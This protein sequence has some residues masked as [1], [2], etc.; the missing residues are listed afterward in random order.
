MENDLYIKRKIEKKVNK[1]EEPRA[2]FRSRNLGTDPRRGQ[3]PN[4]EGLFMEKAKSNFQEWKRKTLS[5]A[6]RVTTSMANSFQVR[7]S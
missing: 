3:L 1:I 5:Q 2:R 4:N 7:C 6:G